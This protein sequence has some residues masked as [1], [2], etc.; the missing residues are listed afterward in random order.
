MTTQT[1]VRQSPLNVAKEWWDEMPAHER[2]RLLLNIR[3]NTDLPMA[4]WRTDFASLASRPLEELP[5][6]IGLAILAL[7]QYKHE[8]AQ[9]DLFLQPAS[10]IIN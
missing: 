10:P 6:G 8:P 2:I 3:E 1:E 7:V 4:N 5:D 9:L